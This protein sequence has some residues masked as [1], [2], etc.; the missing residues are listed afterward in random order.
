MMK[1]P[2]KPILIVIAGP[3][4]SGKT[5]ITQKLLQHEWSQDTVYINPDI[6][7][8]ERFG[9][10]NAYD[11]VMQAAVYATTERDRLLKMGKS[12][13]FET[14]F[15]TAEKF[16]FIQKAKDAGYFVRFFFVCV[17]DPTINAQRVAI[18]VL[19][20]GHD[21]PIRKII[22][23]YYRSLEYALRAIPIVDRAYF[24]DNTKNDA[25]AR[26]MFRTSEGKIAKTY[27]KLSAWAEPIYT[28]LQ[29][30]G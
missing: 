26:L 21:V 17:D 20:G 15:S 28:M 27:T 8:K 11:A 1:V 7:A 9:D 10:W 16:E 18:R 3:N 4:G 30:K 23:R 5:T 2:E 19:E 25:M 14:V 12:I 13:A 22:E 29:E 6:I 24:Y